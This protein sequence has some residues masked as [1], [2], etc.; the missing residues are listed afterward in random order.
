[1][2]AAVRT[3]YGGPEVVDLV[4]LPEPTPGPG[5]I[6][7]RVHATTVNRTDCA[8]RSG[9]P[10]IN[11][12]VCGWPRPRVQVLGSEYAGVVAALGR[13]VEQYAVGDRVLGFV[14]GRA[15][16]HAE[17]VAVPVGSL[18]AP[19]PEGIEM[20]EAAAGM[21]GAHYAHACLRVT[22]IGRGDRA[23]VH[24]A[25]GGIGS[26]AVQ[27]MRAEGVE[28]T[29]VCDRLPPDRPD[30]LTEIGAAHVVVQGRER[31]PA[32]VGSG[33]DVVLDATGH[34]S[35]REALPLLRPGGTYVSSELGRGAQNLVLAAVGPLARAAGRRHA[36]F[37]FPHADADLA[38]HLA[39]LM[40]SGAYRPVVDRTYAFDDLREAYAYVDS[41]RKV[42]N[43]VVVM[44]PRS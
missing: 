3:E 19:V 22:G 11:K 9:H 24:G 18:V 20:A 10:W 34:L 40:A 7:V 21:E 2:R 29:A 27:L 30:L 44:P 42:G 12:A 35:F 36:R 41:G 6:L 32:S 14:E 37:P 15:G 5:E 25:T 4:D 16:A 28:V 1:M 8:Y 39:G 38:A 17:L 33:F 23:L 31:V 13:G 26:A 43:V